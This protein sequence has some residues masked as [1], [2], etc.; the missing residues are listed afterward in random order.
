MKRCGRGAESP[1]KPGLQTL[2]ALTTHHAPRPAMKTIFALITLALAC[3][4]PAAH[5][6]EGSTTV[7]TKD[8]DVFVDLP[9]GFAFVKTPLGWKFVRQLDSEQLSRLPASTLTALLVPEDTGIRLAHPALE[10]SPRALARRAAQL[11][12]ASVAAAPAQ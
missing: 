10:L 12:F 2:P 11:H 9:T 8:W 7:P 3:A 4:L 1:L 5:A 6:G